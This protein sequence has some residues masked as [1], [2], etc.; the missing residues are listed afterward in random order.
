MH[1]GFPNPESSP[2][3]FPT[4][5]PT[6]PHP[7]TAPMLVEAHESLR[8]PLL[9]VVG[10][11]GARAPV[12]DLAVVERNAAVTLVIPHQ[13]A[14][15]AV[16]DRLAAVQGDYLASDALSEYAAAVSRVRGRLPRRLQP[17]VYTF[18]N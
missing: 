11:T 12:A 2:A 9:Q 7:Q 8:T 14:L 18:T 3:Q 17:S 4:E 13:Q 16:H 6:N 15:D 10:T 5:S 1:P